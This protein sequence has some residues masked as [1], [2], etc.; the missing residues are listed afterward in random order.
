MIQKYIILFTLC[1]VIQM[2]WGQKALLK[3]ANK[4]FKAND[5]HTAIADYKMLEN[6]DFQAQL[7]LADSYYYLGNM[8]DAASI[9][10]ICN[11]SDTGLNTDALLRYA[12]AEKANN[13]YEEAN[14][15]LSKYA[16]KPVNIQEKLAENEEN[17]PLL[18]DLQMLDKDS[19]HAEFG[20]VLYQDKLVFSSDR[21]NDRPIYKR[22]QQPFL[23]LYIA[24][25]NGNTLT[26]ITLFSEAINTPLHEGNTAFTK[27]GKTIYFTRTN[28]DYKRINGVKVAVLQLFKADFKD[29]T[30]Q[31]IENLPIN[32]DSY[33]LAHPSLSADDKTLY[34]TSDMPGGYGGGDIYKVELLADNNYGAPINLGPSVNSE[35]QE[36]FPYISEEGNLYFASDRFMGLGGLDLY[37][38]DSKDGAFA[39]AYNMGPT[40]NTNRD[41]FSFI[42]DTQNATGYFSSN[43]SGTDKIYHFTAIDNRK[44]ELSGIVINTETQRPISQVVVT[45]YHAETNLEQVKT[46]AQGHY[47]FR[48]N[49]NTNYH[50]EASLQDFQPATRKIIV[51]RKSNLQLEVDLPLQPVHNILAERHL[52]NIYFDFDKAVIRPEAREILDKLADFMQ[53]NPTI[54][55]AIASHT[56]AVGSTSYNKILSEKRAKATK[57][58][59]IN[60]GIDAN[61]MM[62]K[63]CGEKHLLIDTSDS[64]EKEAREEKNRRSE[65][66]IVTE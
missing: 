46:D 19:E 16:G 6:P 11:M 44:H 18:F 3:E 54:K 38:S 47:N 8:R 55:I 7:N 26:D 12:D 14:K 58:H 25:V 65:F 17:L 32:N 53:E 60:K 62:T 29:G 37:R 22:T 23:D 52:D 15:I 45:L 34:F 10:K 35:M 21:N 51:D 56:D 41:D 66:K 43:H 61:R 49:P 1:F 9:Y 27:D 48:L 5:Y 50:V 59:L 33:S 30:W 63:A 64:S 57:N 40:I 31:N 28:E 39:E 20:P 4:A 42:I 24:T 36:Q 13:N 2:S